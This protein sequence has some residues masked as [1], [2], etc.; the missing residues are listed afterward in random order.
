MT[1]TLRSL[2]VA[3]RALF[4]SFLIMV[5]TGY[6]MALSLMFLLDIRPHQEAGLS[7]I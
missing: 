3:F 5:G 7:L 4:T 6:L 2:P 1:I